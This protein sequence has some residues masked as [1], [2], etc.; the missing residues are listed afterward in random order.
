VPVY[1]INI[2]TREASNPLTS[3]HGP[4]TVALRPFAPD[5][6]FGVHAVQ[7][8][9]TRPEPA[10]LLLEYRVQGDLERLRIPA[11]APAGAATDGLWRHTCM[12]VFVADG[13]A[14]EYL[15]FNLAPSGQW[16]AYRFSGYRAGMTPL[17]L[18]PPHIE[19]ATEPGALVLTA[20]L[21][22]PRPPGSTL[23]LGL[24]TVIENDRGQLAYWALRHPGERPDFHHP[25]S[26]GLEI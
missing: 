8:H 22:L 19:C 13:R 11:A 10:R 15:E 4:G 5:P 1:I 6:A 24:A 3:Q 26:F 12:E 21:E 16:A 18:S 20:R 17:A 23:R 2:R 9:G 25:D 14:G 7:V